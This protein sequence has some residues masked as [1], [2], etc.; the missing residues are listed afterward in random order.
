[1]G[2]VSARDRPY[3]DE[4]SDPIDG[5]N[6]KDSSTSKVALDGIVANVKRVHVEGLVRTKEDVVCFISFTLPPAETETLFLP[7]CI[8]QKQLTNI[9][10]LNFILGCCKHR[11]SSKSQT[12]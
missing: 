7:L 12:F 5:A 9:C 3:P 11:T 8:N 4:L 10:M 2:N 1:M 6:R